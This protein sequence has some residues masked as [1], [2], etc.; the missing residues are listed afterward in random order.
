MKRFLLVTALL[1]TGV[2]HAWGYAFTECG[3]GSC[4]WEE[5]PVTYYIQEPLGIDL[6]EEAGRRPAWYADPDIEPATSFQNYYG[7]IGIREIGAL[8]YN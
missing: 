2:G 5:F 6:D 4:H 8:P 7:C 1:L 3:D